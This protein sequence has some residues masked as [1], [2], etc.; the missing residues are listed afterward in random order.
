MI[1]VEHITKK[2]DDFT[3][4]SDVSFKVKDGCIY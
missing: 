4:L 3:A 1:N 2:F